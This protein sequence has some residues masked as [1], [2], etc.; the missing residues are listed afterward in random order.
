M[1]KNLTFY[2]VLLSYNEYVIHVLYTEIIPQLWYNINSL[3]FEERVIYH[4][5]LLVHRDFPPLLHTLQAPPLVP[6][7]AH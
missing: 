3:T 5:H 2:I 1:Q 6:L 7:R 4:H